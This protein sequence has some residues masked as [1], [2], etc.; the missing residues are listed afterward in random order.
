MNVRDTLELVESSPTYA[1]WKKTH[2]KSYLVHFFTMAEDGPL[3][4]EVGYYN[5]DDTISSFVVLGK[6]VELTESAQIFKKTTDAIPTLDL[7]RIHTHFAEV[8][9]NAFSFTQ[10][11]YP[12]EV[13]GKRVVILQQYDSGPIWNITFITRSFKTINMKFDA[14]NGTLIKHSFGSLIDEGKTDEANKNDS[15][16]LH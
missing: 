13:E 14:D 3:I 5:D 7:L 8:L 12:K 9:E 16:N 1:T 6:E 10:K 2:K 4:W 11:E 15:K